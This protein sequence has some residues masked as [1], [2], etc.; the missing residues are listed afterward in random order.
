MFGDIKTSLGKMKD[1]R[2]NGGFED[3]DSLIYTQYLEYCN[4]SGA[5][6]ICGNIFNR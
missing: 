5:T 3:L 1:G 6:D 2:K 4:W